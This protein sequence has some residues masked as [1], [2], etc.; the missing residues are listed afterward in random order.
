MIKNKLGFWILAYD[1]SEK[2]AEEVG[3]CTENPVTYF[4]NKLIEWS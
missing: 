2:Y 1:E 3:G 4:E